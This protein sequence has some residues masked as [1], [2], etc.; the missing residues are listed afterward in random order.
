[1]RRHADFEDVALRRLRLWLH[2]SFART[3]LESSGRPT[4][5]DVGAGRG[6]EA[7]IRRSTPSRGRC[8]RYC[9]SCPTRPRHRLVPIGTRA[10]LGA[11][12]SA[13]RIPPTPCAR[14]RGDHQRPLLARQAGAWSWRPFA[15]ASARLRRWTT[16]RPTTTPGPVADARPSRVQTQA[17]RC[18]RHK[19]GLNTFAVCRVGS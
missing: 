5:V 12:G 13:G 7:R 2:A 10:P 8:P 19:F 4:L 14:R 6:S 11:A 1:M 17:I 3:Q 16:T 18:H 9:L 15:S